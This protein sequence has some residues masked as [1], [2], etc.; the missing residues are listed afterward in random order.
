MPGGGAI[1][2]SKTV[3]PKPQEHTNKKAIP[4]K[5]LSAD[6]GKHKMLKKGTL[7]KLCKKV[8]WRK[9]SPSSGR[10]NRD[11]LAEEPMVKGEEKNGI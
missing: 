11:Q 2:V 3:P 8:F 10:L 5:M 6:K 7:H 9:D 1:K 4:N